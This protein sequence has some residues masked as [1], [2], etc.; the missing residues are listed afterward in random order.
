ME[1]ELLR[2]SFGS[3]AAVFARRLGYRSS[4][5]DLELTAR[6][7][8]IGSLF[9]VVNGVVNMFFAFR[10]AGGLAQYWVILV[11][12]PI[13]KVTE[14]LPRGSLLNPGPFSPK[15]HTLVMTMAIAGSLA[16][17]LGLS[18]GMLALTLDYNTRLDSVQIYA[19]ALMAGFFGIF[20][21]TF[22][23]ES[24]VLPDKYQWP[25]SRANAAFIAAFYREVDAAT[26][27]DAQLIAAFAPG[28]SDRG[29]RF[30]GVGASLRVFGAFFIVTFCW[31]AMPNYL[32]P[33]LLTMPVLCW[34]HPPVW[35][36]V[37]PFG[38]GGSS[39][40]FSVLSSGVAGSGVPGIGGWASSFAF[41]P[42]LIPLETTIW[43]VVG[44]MLTS[45]LF[46]PA[47]FFGGV[48]AWPSS[49]REFTS[50]GSYYNV[51]EGHYGH[52][53]EQP[54]L[55]GV[56]MTM[57]AGVALSI[58]SMFT[59]CAIL[60]CG[61]LRTA[62]G[63]ATATP[64]SRPPTRTL[65]EVEATDVH[66]TQAHQPE[67]G[68]G[69]GGIP[70]GVGS[71]GGIV[72]S[73]D[74][75]GSAADWQSI[76]DS[77]GPQYEACRRRPVGLKANVLV[78]CAMTLLAA[79][80]VELVLPRYRGQPG[81]GTPLWM[82]IFCIVY[83]FCSSFGCA[84]IYALIGQNFSGGVCI[85]MQVIC[86]VLVP[87]SARANIVAVMLVNSGVSQ[88]MGVL[89]D[90][91]TALYL[92]VSPRAMLK[93]QLLGALVGVLASATTFIYVIRLNDEGKIHLGSGEWPAIGAVSIALNAKVFGE[94]GPSA[95]IRGALLYIVI[96]CTA[97][98][99]VGTLVLAAIPERYKWKRYLPSPLLLGVAGLYSGINF[100]STSLL[101][102][103]LV[104]QLYLR[105][106]CPDWFARFQY[107]ST[108][109]VNAGVGLAGL[110]VILF[111]SMS[112]PF[113]TLGPL[114]TGDCT[115]V[116]LPAVT[117]EDV[118]CWNMI[119]GF[120]GCNTPWPSN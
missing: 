1:D 103:A 115:N 38:R 55:S 24:L 116:G 72:G 12:Y 54:Y 112:I 98:G 89:G 5:N 102:I 28:A 48:A 46:V 113:V 87:G 22:F 21:G 92:S 6:A 66:Y 109:G 60:L 37:L 20:F 47:V 59:E 50:N 10:Y 95:I 3:D 101:L 85:L 16:G 14:L 23:F 80:V 91:K 26:N 84:L 33:T 11:A 31:F 7:I 35:R 8:V 34:I 105:K 19:W 97:F 15:E 69:G 107:V 111:T 61:T 114:P 110:L 78:V 67:P 82:T 99:V 36:G 79:C 53:N 27:A 71:G 83:G 56:G 44:S 39:D 94:Q 9:A 93:A 51:S 86:G 75:L 68:S 29:S 96:G 119:N 117:D 77:D 73:P 17:T 40:V 74:G 30:S 42:S 41:G 108:S 49:F 57:Y 76:R 106:R 88:A 25:F 70:G 90:L 32:V 118:A 13:C 100:S 104:Y 2:R 18:G 52:T 43:I 63:C 64:S 120:S 4:P 65:S 58:V 62:Y 81:L 45:W